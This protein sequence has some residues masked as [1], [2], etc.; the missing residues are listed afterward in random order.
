MTGA[1]AQPL[2]AADLPGDLRGLLARWHAIACGAVYDLDRLGFGPLAQHLIGVRTTIV[3]LPGDPGLSGMEARF[4][5]FSRD[6]DLYDNASLL[7]LPFGAHPEPKLSELTL[8]SYIEV[9]N[10][11]RP[12]VHRVRLRMPHRLSAY[13][14]CS[15]PIMSRG[16]I[17][18]LLTVSRRL[19]IGKLHLR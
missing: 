16:R 2:A 8:A 4:I 18:K 9:L 11:R 7:G 6:F 15:F 14:K 1:V 10:A 12:L 19:M 13:L 5:Y 17:R 3:Q